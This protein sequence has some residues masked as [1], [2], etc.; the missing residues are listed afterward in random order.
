M[1]AKRMLLLHL[2][3]C[4]IRAALMLAV[5]KED[6]GEM[7]PTWSGAGPPDVAAVL[8][9]LAQDGA[10]LQQRDG[11]LDGPAQRAGL[12]RAGVCLR[13]LG[14]QCAVCLL[15]RADAHLHATTV[16]LLLQVT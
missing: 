11:A 7:K 9:A 8:A 5:Q 14:H 3:C 6:T 13:R 12:L 10:V 4:Q 1:G 2:L 16:S 15:E